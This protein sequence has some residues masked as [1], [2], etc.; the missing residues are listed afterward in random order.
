MI[1]VIIDIDSVSNMHMSS[2]DNLQSRARLEDGR[3]LRL[4]SVE[5]YINGL[6]KRPVSLELLVD[7]VPVHRFSSVDVG[8]DKRA[9]WESKDLYI[10]PE[11]LM[12]FILR[13]KHSLKFKTEM[14]RF[15]A[16]GN[17]A[18]KC[19]IDGE[20]QI[21]ELIVNSTKA[22]LKL[23]FHVEESYRKSVGGSAAHAMESLQKHKEVLEK[24][25]NVQ[26]FIET[27]L[28]FTDPLAEAKFPY[29]EGRTL[30]GRCGLSGATFLLFDSDLMFID[31]INE[32]KV[33]DQQQ[34]D[35]VLF[36][37][38]DGMTHMLPFVTAVQ[39]VA[40]LEQ[41]KDI[42]KKMLKSIEQASNFVSKY[43]S[44]H[45]IMKLLV[46]KA[47][48]DVDGFVAHFK[49]LKEDYDRST[50]VEILQSVLSSEEQAWLQKLPQAPSAN[51]DPV[52]VCMEGTRKK[53]LSQIFEWTKS[54]TLS[55]KLFWLSGLAGAGKSSIATTVAQ[56]LYQDK[57]LGGC[58]FCKRDDPVLRDASRILPTFASRLAQIFGPYAKLLVEAL[59]RDAG[60]GQ[61]AIQ[62]QFDG[63]F[64]YPLEQLQSS[65]SFARHDPIVF[66]VDALDE[67]G[68]FASRRQILTCLL[69]L[70]RLVPCIKVFITSRPTEDI[71][72]IFLQA[73]NLSSV[74]QFPLHEDDAQE[75]IFLYS[76]KWV[77]KMTFEERLSE[78][79]RNDDR[80]RQLSSKA[81]GLFIWIATAVSYVEEAVVPEER[82]KKLI[83][84][85]DHVGQTAELDRLYTLI[86][87]DGMG[88]GDDNKH[89]F[90][91]VLGTIIS[92]A[93]CRPLPDMA[94]SQLL[95]L[96]CPQ[97][98][99]KQVF[100]RLQSVLYQ[101]K[102]NQDSIRVSHPSFM[103]FLTTK[104]RCTALGFWVDLQ[105]EDA[106][107]ALRCLEI[108]QNG[109]TQFNICGIS[110]SHSLNH[111]VP[112]L[113][114]RIKQRISLTLQYS[115]LYWASHLC[116]A[117]FSAEQTKTVQLSLESFLPDINIL[118]WL[119]IISLIKEIPSLISA[120]PLVVICLKNG[121]QIASGM[122]EGAICTWDTRTGAAVFQP[123]AKH[124]KQVTCL[125]YSPDGQVIASGSM[126]KSICIW[127]S[128]SGGSILEPLLGHRQGISSL[129]YSPDGNLL[130]S[131][132]KDGTLRIWDAWNGQL[133]LKPLS[134]HEGMVRSVAFSPDKLHIASGS[135]DESIIIWNSKKGRPA[136][137]EP[138]KG[139]SDT[140]TS[141]AYSPDGKLLASG[142]E[143]KTII[144]WDAETG[145]MKFGPI[146]G[147][148]GWVNSV[149]FSPDGDYIASGSSDKSV[150]VWDAE[151]GAS[152]C[153]P[154]TGHT[155]SITSIAYAPIGPQIASA[156]LDKF[157]RIW[158]VEGSAKLATNDPLFHVKHSGEVY[159]VA[160]SDDG[161]L[162]ASGSDDMSVRIWSA[163]TGLAERQALIGHEGIVTSVAFSP[164]GPFVASGSYDKTVMVWD[165]KTG[166]LAYPALLHDEYVL[167][168]AYSPT[169][170]HLAASTAMNDCAIHIWEAAT[171]LRAR[172]PLR[173]HEGTVNSLVYS[174]D[175]KRLASGSNDYK[176]IIWNVDQGEAIL[177][178]TEYQSNIN[179]ISFSTDDF[180][181]YIA[182][183]NGNQIC[184][185]DSVTG[186]LLHE[187]QRPYDAINMS[188]CNISPDGKTVVSN[189][190][191]RGV[192]Y[193]LYTWDI[194]TG[195][196]ERFS[197]HEGLIRSM[198]YSKDGSQLV[199]GS[200]DGTI[201]V[202]DT[203]TLKKQVDAQELVAEAQ[204]LQ[205]FVPDD[206]WVRT[207]D[208]GLLLWVPAEHRHGVY[209]KSMMTIPTNAFN[210]SM[211]LDC[212]KFCHGEAWTNVMRKD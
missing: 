106:S 19:I 187:M 62:L 178:M 86:V 90:H 160:L 185:W 197:G 26:T 61:Q 13:E 170:A 186:A 84:S 4:R 97:P 65:G 54:D 126:D 132:S 40:K 23:E 147:H 37:L 9:L 45:Y 206:G 17:A 211:R 161:K 167:S 133:L 43:M 162:I 76:R 14:C 122:R 74:F 137:D 166:M 154:L 56:N 34:C 193:P 192:D 181:K 113:D 143:D 24:F 141:V 27:V 41:T 104:E 127:D 31:E 212:T 63:L 15:K 128:K 138:L 48:Q 195:R 7:G 73:V 107:R 38:L 69:Q 36:D 101:D 64:R 103:D 81:T 171:G 53:I 199:T 66:V 125:A 196:L 67:C 5:V 144:I 209:D 155:S 198:V 49:Q 1:D 28:A 190:S 130:V 50:T 205:N 87:S 110:S 10:R 180:G 149:A 118:Y 188:L 102:R 142:S 42:I 169:G 182:S 100:I 71:S 136:F 174:R 204:K 35:D 20:D 176:I 93:L 8:K 150:Q 135:S 123:L 79:W 191:F 3:H 159:T 189:P 201:R 183:S 91:S 96:D 80:I 194:A 105:E 94:L 109:A 153:E 200:C 98:A 77:E 46:P 12:L 119:E 29:C 99:V 47:R 177:E 92:V 164:A 157:I 52:K 72:R 134:A 75:D 39:D 11:S 2:F 203:G 139:H 207:L 124:E 51:F 21:G 165:L 120:L 140:I 210:H 168:V 156:S 18:L 78:V 175:G 148:T 129:A 44:E 152:V 173:G 59:K 115:S 88:T 85:S 58:F 25:S 89:Y 117:S 158:D 6:A 131:A 114:L 146:T 202:W 108:V 151:T 83:S 116:S 68:E 30:Y 55:K 208:G 179:V 145:K 70:Q 33:L 121:E 184:V 82:L 57:L 16:D 111:E 112:G 22:K 163:E 95:P 60:L 32:Q 172:E